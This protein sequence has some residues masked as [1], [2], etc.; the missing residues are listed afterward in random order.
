MAE[1]TFELHNSPMTNAAK[2][3]YDSFYILEKLIVVFLAEFHDRN[4]HVSTRAQGWP[5]PIFT[6]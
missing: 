1:V 3:Y 2:S 4:M 6:P 5:L